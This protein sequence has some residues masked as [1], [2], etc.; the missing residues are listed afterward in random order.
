M[1]LLNTNLITLAQNPPKSSDLL[2][3]Q[4]LILTCSCD[5]PVAKLCPTFFIPTDCSTPV[6]PVHCLQSLLRFMSIETVTLS[7]HLILCCPLLLLPSIFPSIRVFSNESAL[8]IRWP[9]YWSFSYSSS[10]S[11][12]YSGLI[13]FRMDWFDLLAVQGTL[14]ESSPAPRCKGINSLVLSLLYGSALTSIHDDWKKT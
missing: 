13:F 3:C 14:E 7:N 12:E 10:P 5:C 4:C 9:K 1:I 2:K 11:K 6:S 8:C